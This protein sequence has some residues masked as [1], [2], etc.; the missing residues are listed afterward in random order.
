MA[1]TSEITSYKWRET[2]DVVQADVRKDDKGIIAYLHASPNAAHL[3][4]LQEIFQGKG[5]TGSPDIHNGRPVLR[6]AGLQ[7]SDDLI[8][9]LQQAGYAQGQAAISEPTPPEEGEKSLSSVKRN[10]LHASSALYLL[11]D[12]LAV[13]SGIKR[14]DKEQ[15]GIGV[16]FA[17]G[18]AGFMA[19]GGHNEHR[20]F[21]AT[22]KSLRKHLEKNNIAIPQDSAIDAELLTTRGGFL[23][24]VH[25]YVS[26]HINPFKLLAE[27]VGGV[28]TFRAGLNQHNP[29]KT[30]AGAVL[31]AGWLSALL[32]K[33]KKIDPEAYSHAGAAQKLAMKVQAQP[34]LLAGGSG[35]TNNAFN[36]YGAWDERRRLKAGD[37]TATPH[38]VWDLAMQTAMVGAN[39]LFSIS[40][41]NGKAVSHE[42]P[43]ID[44]VYGLAAKTFSSLPEN[45]RERALEHTAEFLAERHSIPEN[46]TQAVEKL[47]KH[48]ELMAHNPWQSPA[49][50]Q[51][52]AGSHQDKLNAARDAATLSGAPTR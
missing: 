2:G 7:N 5:W 49:P 43:L 45:V 13:I 15:I 44:D 36:Y 33:E 17:A 24:Q 9:F 29:G 34:L 26:E 16:S 28:F 41:K 4:E 30:A 22:L 40:K 10:S 11:G 27:V 47:R 38:Y 6:L 8:N 42:D 21:N 12:V 20:T 1:H 35:L 18:D 23:E 52:V 50:A 51:I 14:N 48:M 46:K 32:I 19:F 31:V 39:V 25:D 3:H 37:P